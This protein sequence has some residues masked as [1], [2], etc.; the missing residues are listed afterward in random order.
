[1]F[2][3][4]HFFKTLLMKPLCFCLWSLSLVGLAFTLLFEAPLTK[5]ITH[6]TNVKI[7]NPH[8]Y[9]MIPG[10]EG[11]GYLQRKLSTLPGV[12]RVGIVSEKVL[13]KKIEGLM[14]DLSGDESLDSFSTSFAAIDVIMAKGLKKRS[15]NLIRDY[16]KRVSSNKEIT[17]GPVIR[18]SSKKK[19]NTFL[20]FFQQYFLLFLAVGS[21]LL[22]IASNAL[23]L[24]ELRKQSFLVENF[25]RKSL[26]F[27]KSFS[28]GQTPIMLALIIAMAMEIKVAYFLF[29]TILCS[30]FIVHLIG[31]RV[32]Q[33]S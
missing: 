22:Y 26:V 10:E 24:K 9:A 3:L 27:S 12:K 6:L 18:S 11:L 13:S 21:F 20:G 25:Q 31:K 8:F 28:S 29:I 19:G 5:S 4:N 32:R 15:Q 16:L 33:W 2:Y 7:D 23:F 1:M 14:G 17:L 30:L